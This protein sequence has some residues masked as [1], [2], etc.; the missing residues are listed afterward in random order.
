MTRALAFILLDD[1]W[2]ALDAAVSERMDCGDCKAAAGWCEKCAGLDKAAEQVKQ[3]WGHVRIV[4][5]DEQAQEIVKAVIALLSDKRRYGD[6]GEVAFFG[7][8]SERAA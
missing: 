8:A 7:V 2:Q 4:Q 1:A 6:A 5:S 3:A